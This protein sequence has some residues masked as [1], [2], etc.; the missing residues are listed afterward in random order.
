[1][2]RE[3]KAGRGHMGVGCQRERERKREVLVLNREGLGV[4]FQKC[5]LL[6]PQTVFFFSFTVGLTHFRSD[7]LSDRHRQM[8]RKKKKEEER[9]NGCSI[10][11]E[12]RMK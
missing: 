9:R 5:H 2:E 10:S 7:W 12:G 1:M 6:V 8:K 11:Y 3:R 4:L